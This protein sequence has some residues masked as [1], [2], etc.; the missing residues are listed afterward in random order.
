MDIIILN[1]LGFHNDRYIWFRAH[2]KK[3]S[4]IGFRH[5]K[6]ASTTLKSINPNGDYILQVKL[7][8]VADLEQQRTTMCRTYC[9]IMVTLH[10]NDTLLHPELIRIPKGLEFPDGVARQSTYY[11]KVS[12]IRRTKFPNFN[13]SRL[14]LYLSAPNPMTAGV[15]SRMK[16]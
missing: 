12:N 2:F 14:V 5:F 8:D 15:K 6:I 4:L 1:E 13:V 9:Y 10:S 11:R 3:F 16:K 7:V